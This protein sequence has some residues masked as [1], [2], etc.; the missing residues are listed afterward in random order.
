MV[1][2]AV[3]AR[4]IARTVC[5]IMRYEEVWRPDAPASSSRPHQP[6]AVLA[7]VKTMPPSAVAFGQS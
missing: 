6:A 2:A 3:L 4:K 7:A 1:A 5:A